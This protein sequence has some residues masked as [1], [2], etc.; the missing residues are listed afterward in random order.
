LSRASA[1]RRSRSRYANEIIA[2]MAK[3]MTVTIALMTSLVVN[4]LRI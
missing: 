2:A 1:R 3:T 4:T